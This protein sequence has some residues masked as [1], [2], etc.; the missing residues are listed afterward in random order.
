MITPILTALILVTQIHTEIV[1]FDQNIADKVFKKKHPAL[2]LL[3]G[4]EEK[5]SYEFGAF[6]RF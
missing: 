2:L 4:D 5:E 1:A 6:A 3:L